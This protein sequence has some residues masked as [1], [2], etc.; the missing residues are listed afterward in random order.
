MKRVLVYGTFD[1][2]HYGHL[3]LLRKAKELSNNG[4]LIVGVNSDSYIKTRGKTVTIPC[5]QRYAII[6]AIKY[7]DEVFINEYDYTERL[8]D[9]LTHN[10]DIVIVNE[11][12]IDKFNYL[13]NAGIQIMHLT[14]TPNISTTKIKENIKNVKQ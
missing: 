1:L 13:T 14:R 5:E 11:E 10:I 3:E 7:V 4:K 6:N 12:S 2:F 9:I 8:N